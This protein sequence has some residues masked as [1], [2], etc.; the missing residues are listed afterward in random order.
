[1]QS[2]ITMVPDSFS[3]GLQG[4]HQDDDDDDDDDDVTMIC[5][6]IICIF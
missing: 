1:M 3:V 4:C 2:T 6:N 5:F